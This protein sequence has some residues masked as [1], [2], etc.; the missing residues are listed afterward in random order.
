VIL[1]EPVTGGDA[2]G[3]PTACG[4]PEPCPEI[5]ELHAVSVMAALQTAMSVRLIEGFIG[6]P[7]KLRR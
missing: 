2:G 7:P 4:V 1:K 6:L 5:V 3:G